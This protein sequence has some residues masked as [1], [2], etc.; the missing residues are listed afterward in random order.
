MTGHDRLSSGWAVRRVWLPRR[1]AS[2]CFYAEPYPS[3]LKSHLVSRPGTS[4]ALPEPSPWLHMAGRTQVNTR[5]P[6]KSR[7]GEESPF[8]RGG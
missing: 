6:P 2:R 3:H 5:Q 8:V 7:N 1:P 4:W